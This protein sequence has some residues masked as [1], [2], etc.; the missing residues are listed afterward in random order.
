MILLSLGF[1]MCLTQTCPGS[2]NVAQ[3]S[4]KEAVSALR[5]LKTEL[6]ASRRANAELEAKNYKLAEVRT[7]LVY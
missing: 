5:S 3:M 4:L 2:F 1:A 7:R 6:E